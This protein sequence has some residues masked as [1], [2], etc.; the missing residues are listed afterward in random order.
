MKS[1]MALVALAWTSRSVVHAEVL[2]WDDGP[3]ETGWRPARPTA[4]NP[5]PIVDRA[6]EP[7]PAPLL[8]SQALLQPRGVNNRTL[9][10]I[11]GVLSSFRRCGDKSHMTS[12]SR[13]KVVDCC[14]DRPTTPCHPATSCL[15]LSSVSRYPAIGNGT[16]L[17]TARPYTSCVKY[18]YVDESITGYSLWWCGMSVTTR[19]ILR[20]ATESAPPG[21]TSSTTDEPDEIAPPTVTVI[22]YPPPTST[23][24]I[25]EPANVPAVGVIAGSVAGAV[26]VVLLAVLGVFLYRR[27]RRS[28]KDGQAGPVNGNVP[29]MEA[30]ASPR[31][32]SELEAMVQPREMATPLSPAQQVGFGPVTPVAELPAEGTGWS[33]KM[34]HGGS[35]RG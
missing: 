21:E 22:S 30:K 7:T 5:H 11:A 34:H 18:I 23:S 16:T 10:Y 27:R 32:M 15:P 9:G 13:S 12:W 31:P 28:K 2:R 17:C 24:N 14:P 4:G 8:A 20:H 26:V 35:W 6:P 3:D 1:A 19:N 29:G 25:Q 33:N